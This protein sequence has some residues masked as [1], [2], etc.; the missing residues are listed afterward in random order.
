MGAAFVF[1]DSNATTSD[2]QLGTAI[3]TVNGPPVVAGDGLR[4]VPLWAERDNGR[5]PTTIYVPED[6]IVGPVPDA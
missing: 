3:G 6:N 1:L 4:L 2:G 5:E